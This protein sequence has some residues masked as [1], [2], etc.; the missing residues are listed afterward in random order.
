MK[1]IFKISLIFIFCA[2]VNSCVVTETAY[3]QPAAVSFQVFYDALSPYGRWVNYPSYGFVWIPVGYADFYPYASAGY[4]A[5]ADVGWT[6]V[7]HYPWGWAPFHYGKWFYDGM[8]GWIWIPGTE[9]GPAW[10]VWINAPGYYGWAPIMPGYGY[11]IHGYPVEYWTFVPEN[12]FG[13]KTVYYG[14]RSNNAAIVNRATLVENTFTDPSRN[15]SYYSGPSKEAVQRSTGREVKPI[16]IREVSGRPVQEVKNDEFRIYRPKVQEKTATDKTPAPARVTDIKEI[17]REPVKIVFP[18]DKM[19]VKNPPVRDRG[20]PPVP[21]GKDI[22]ADQKKEVPAEKPRP[23]AAPQEKDRKIQPPPQPQ[24][25]PVIDR[26]KERPA[27]PLLRG[28]KPHQKGINPQ[29]FPAATDNQD[30]IAIGT[31]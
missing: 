1:S 13:K 20:T 18:P 10:V 27:I 7:S 26:Q 22:P 12:D 4:W 31:K 2:S 8:Y 29:K 28:K 11:H 23:Q 19:G 16:A 9:W 14:P 24:Q 21:P 30:S 15:E 3:P 17:G 25:K 5:Y 6:W